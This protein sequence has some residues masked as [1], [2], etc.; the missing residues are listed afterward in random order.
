ME[1]KQRLS[2]TDWARAA[3]N[4]IGEH[5]LAGVAVERLAVRLGTTKGSFYWHFPSRD[6]LVAAALELWDET[7]TEAIIRAVQ[8]EPD[9]AARL[10]ALFLGVTP[11]PMAPIEVN[12]LAAADHP[13]V[14]P[15]MRRAV[16]RRVGYVTSLFTALGF[17]P[18]EAGRRAVLAYEAYL[19][20]VQLVARMPDALPPRGPD[21]DAYLDTVLAALSTPP[22]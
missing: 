4:A 9:P 18:E 6:A 13:L 21:L 16:A 3:L 2:A 8:A 17:P 5:G 22:P 20:H 11:S 7:H 14:A 12:L 10:R 19:G 1:R 15:A